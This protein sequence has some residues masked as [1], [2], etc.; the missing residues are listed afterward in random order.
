MNGFFDIFSVLSQSKSHAGL[1]G[2][3]VVGAAVGLC[4]PIA[5]FGQRS[6]V[7]VLVDLG[8]HG[9]ELVLAEVVHDARADGVAQDVDGSSVGE[10]STSLS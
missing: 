5:V 4:G 6:D 8:T 10:R 1:V 2:E 7:P 3:A 9:V